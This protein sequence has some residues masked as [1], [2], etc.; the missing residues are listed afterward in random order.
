MEAAKLWQA[1]GRARYFDLPDLSPDYKNFGRVY[2]ISSAGYTTYAYRD[3]AARFEWVRQYGIETAITVTDH[4]QEHNFD[5]AFAVVKYLAKQASFAEAF[6][7]KLAKSLTEAEL[8][9]L[10][11]GRLSLTTGTLSTRTGNVLRL[12]DVVEAAAVAASDQIKQR[13]SELAEAELDRRARA[14]AIA[15][16]K[17]ADLDRDPVT[18]VVLD[19]AQITAFE[20]DTGTYQL[21]TYAR[22]GSVLRKANDLSIKTVHRI[23][24][25]SLER[26][27]KE[28]LQRAYSFPLAVSAAADAL[29]VNVVADHIGSLSSAISTWYEATPILK[30]ADEQ[31][32]ESL[33][34]MCGILMH[35]LR[36]G[37]DLLG[38]DVLEE[39]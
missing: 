36:V 35:Q 10:G 8:V 38:I 14:V 32:Q 23:Y 22:L 39:L 33:L 17:W 12:T 30:E 34:A 37:L 25:D 21:Y 11:Y 20:G 18:D 4:R 29:R 24:A 27:E 15:S 9:H 26:P 6:D 3:V 7:Q 16:L 31:R 19:P 13:D 28:L 1:D 5:Q 2:L